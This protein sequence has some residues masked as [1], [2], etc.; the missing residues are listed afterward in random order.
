MPP[1]RQTT[2]TPI[3]V[4]VDRGATCLTVLNAFLYVWVRHGRPGPPHRRGGGVERRRNRRDDA[5]PESGR[6]LGEVINPAGFKVGLN[7]RNRGWGENRRSPTPACCSALAA[8]H[9]LDAGTCRHPPDT[10]VVDRHPRCFSRLSGDHL[11]QRRISGRP[12]APPPSGLAREG[13]MGL[14]ATPAERKH[15]GRQP[16]PQRCRTHAPGANDERS[17]DGRDGCGP[18]GHSS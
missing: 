8:E 7:L 10:P 9:Q 3:W 2:R 15:P 16:L 11:D 4:V 13:A 17:V 5:A 6:S 1:L 18:K 12:R 14:W